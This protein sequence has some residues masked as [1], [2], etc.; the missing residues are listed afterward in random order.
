MIVITNSF[1]IYCFIKFILVKKLFL[2]VACDPRKKTF[3]L[4]KKVTLSYHFLLICGLHGSFYFNQFGQKLFCFQYGCRKN[5]LHF[6]L[7][8]SFSLLFLPLVFLKLYPLYSIKKC[9]LCILCIYRD[10]YSVFYIELAVS[11]VFYIELYAL[12]SL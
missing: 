8:I 2:N 12:Y 4:K 1:R 3:Y 5:I 6:K 11:S 10:V 7:K 9:I